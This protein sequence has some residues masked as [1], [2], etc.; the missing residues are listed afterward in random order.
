MNRPAP[1][2]SMSMAEFDRRPFRVGGALVDPVSRDATFA[3]GSE[4]LQPQTLKVL[5]TL[6][7]RQG[8][9]VTREE[10]VHLCWDGRI[11]GEDVINR[12]ISLLRHFAERAGGFTI[13]TVPRTG[14]RLRESSTADIRKRVLAAAVGVLA[15]AGI[16]TAAWLNR[17]SAKQGA[18][19]APTIQAATACEPSWRVTPR[20]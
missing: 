1:R 17:P 10:L 3:G 13:E 14:Y 20:T 15:L 6:A 11:V 9:V 8:A 5:M 4:R 18:P 7:G 2:R 19:D 16:G 12:S